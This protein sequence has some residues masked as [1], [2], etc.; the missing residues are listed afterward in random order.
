[1][2][3]WRAPARPTCPALA[4]A[5]VRHAGSSGKLSPPHEGDVRTVH[6]TVPHTCLP[7]EHRGMTQL[8][9]SPSSPPY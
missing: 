8:C 5:G 3:T 7:C 4:L 9:G 2:G 6:F 1:M